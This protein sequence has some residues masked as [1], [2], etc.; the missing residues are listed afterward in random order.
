[1]DVWKDIGMIVGIFGLL[2]QSIRWR[3]HC[4]RYI[5]LMMLCKSTCQTMGNIR[6][7]TRCR[8]NS[9]RSILRDN[10]RAD[11][12][13]LRMFCLSWKRLP[14]MLLRLLLWRWIRVDFSTILRY[15]AWIS[16]LMRSFGRGWSRSTRILV[17]SWPVHCWLRSSHRC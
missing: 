6:R 13:F 14:L 9:F 1:M 16:W 3:L 10:I 17:W 8:M 4:L 2:R 15:L 5:W 12:T 7:L 11:T